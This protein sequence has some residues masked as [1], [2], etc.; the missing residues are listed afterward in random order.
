[1]QE[2]SD[3]EMEAYLNY[4]LRMKKILKIGGLILVVFLTGCKWLLS[5]VQRT[6]DYVLR[7]ATKNDFEINIDTINPSV[8]YFKEEWCPNGDGFCH[9]EFEYEGNHPDFFKRLK[10]LP[11]DENLLYGQIS[12]HFRKLNQGYYLFTQDPVDNR[13]FI[14]LIIDHENHRGVLYYE[15]L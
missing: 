7:V 6:P 4:T 9:I 13:N 15:Y 5:D 11:T 8:S 2:V 1:M 14:I 10:R 3:L 12:E